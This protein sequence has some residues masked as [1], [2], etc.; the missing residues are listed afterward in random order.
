M[1]HAYTRV[2]SAHRPR[3]RPGLEPRAAR[4]PR[5]WG[6]PESRQQTPVRQEYPPGR[7][8]P[9]WFAHRPRPLRA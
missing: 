4:D 3:A 8:R 7:R 6:A 2:V 5:R 9:C 1:A